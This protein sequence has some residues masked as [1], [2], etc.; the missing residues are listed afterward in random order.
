MKPCCEIAAM[1]QRVCL[2]CNKPKRCKPQTTG[3][4]HMKIIVNGRKFA[5]I[6][7]SID[8]TEAVAVKATTDMGE[9]TLDV[10]TVAPLDGGL[11]FAERELARF[12]HRLAAVKSVRERTGMGLKDSKNLVDTV[13]T[14]EQYKT[15]PRYTPPASFYG[16]DRY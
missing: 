2:D 6:T 16:D 7:G 3:D 13:P 12:G 10:S 8:F 14:E 5:T 9:V 15:P 11:T 1:F 4:C